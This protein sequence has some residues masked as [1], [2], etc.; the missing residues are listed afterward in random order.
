MAISLLKASAFSALAVNFVF[1]VDAKKSCRK[2]FM[3]D[4]CA[5]PE[6]VEWAKTASPTSAESTIFG[7]KLWLDASKISSV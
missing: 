5:G 6:L 1:A 2:D 4:K 3:D 7:D